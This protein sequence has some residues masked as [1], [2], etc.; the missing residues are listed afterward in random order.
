MGRWTEYILVQGYISS[1]Q[2]ARDTRYMT[3]WNCINHNDETKHTKHCAQQFIGP[4]ERQFRG[5]LQSAVTHWLARRLQVPPCSLETRKENTIRLGKHLT[6]E[7]LQWLTNGQLSC[8]TSR[9]DLKCDLWGEEH[10]QPAG[11]GLQLRALWNRN[12]MRGVFRSI[13]TNT[14]R[15]NH[16]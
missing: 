4:P 7:P 13:K 5:H 1:L 12:H 9:P 11:L 6:S 10:Y 14:Q 2:S 16:N 3:Y 15:L 8:N